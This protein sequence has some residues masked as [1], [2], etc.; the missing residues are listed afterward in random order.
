MKKKI[1]RNSKKRPPTDAN[2]RLYYTTQQ[3][4]VAESEISCTDAPLKAASQKKFKF[5]SI[6]PPNT[7]SSSTVLPLSSLQ[8]SVLHDDKEDATVCI[9]SSASL[10]V[11]GNLLTNHVKTPSTDDASAFVL[12]QNESPIEFIHK[13]DAEIPKDSDAI[14]SNSEHQV[15][16]TSTGLSQ[17]RDSTRTASTTLSLSPKLEEKYIPWVAKALTNS[18]GDSEGITIINS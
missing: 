10:D 1:S 9:T 12:K 4:E 11:S 6:V 15:V 2:N 18:K 3:V 8:F 16:E 5:D 7:T 17:K 13:R 14:L